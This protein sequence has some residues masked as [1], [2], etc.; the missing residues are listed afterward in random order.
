MDRI[1]TQLYILAQIYIAIIHQI[2]KKK[3][4][5]Q[6]GVSLCQCHRAAVAS[7]GD[8]GSSPLSELHHKARRGTGAESS[9]AG[10]AVAA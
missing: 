10:V 2:N 9:R 7:H 3:N 4:N 5:R 1:R 8:V 6:A